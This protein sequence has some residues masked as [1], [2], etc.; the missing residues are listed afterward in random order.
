MKPSLCLNMIV[1]N[2]ADRIER[3]LVSAL[4][5]VKSVVIY[6]TISSDDTVD[7]ITTM[8]QN[9]D[10]PYIVETGEFRDFSYA[11]N[12][13][14]KL[15]KR[16]NGHH[17][18]PF[19][20][21]VLL[22]DADMEL[23]V[24]DG[25]GWEELFNSNALSFDMMQKAGGISYANRRIVNLQYPNDNIYVGV[26]HEYI[27][28]APSGMIKGAHFVDHADGSNRKDKYL[29]DAQ[30]LEDALK[31]DPDNGRSL[32]YL[33]NTYSDWGDTDPSKL[34]LAANAYMKRIA[35]GGW[36]EEKHSSMMRLADV[37]RKRGFEDEYV[38]RMLNAFAFRPTRVE[39][40]YWLA[41]YYRNKGEPLA[42]LMF[43]KTG[44][45]I[46]R[47]DDLLFVNDFAYEWGCR[48][49]YSIAG[50]YDEK[51]RNS[52]FQV[53]ND[54]A[55]DP[56]CPDWY[57]YSCR[58]NLYW[59]TKPLKEHCP[60]MQR[61]VVTIP[62][63]A[64]YVAMNPS[65][66]VDVGGHINCNF[67]CVNYKIDEQ[68]RYMIGPLEC[69]DAA[70]ET[71]NFL[72]KLDGEFNVIKM[73]EILWDRPAAKFDK[74]IGLEDIRLYR[75]KG[76][77]WFNACVREQASNGTCQQWRGKLVHDIDDKYMLVKDDGPMSGEDAIEKNWMPISGSPHHF[78]YRLDKIFNAV[79]G[80]TTKYPTKLAVG[81]IAGG[82]Q[83]I[84][85][86][87]GYICVVHEASVGPDN[88]RTYWHRF[89]WLNHDL[90]LRRL[91]L[92]FV[93]EDQQIEFCAGLAFHPNGSDFML[94]Y[95]VRD[96]E[97]HFA[98]V[99]MEEVAQM[100]WKFHES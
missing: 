16:H 32:F 39:P 67:R 56:A 10:I 60:S 75:H 27:D 13:A 43:A 48:Y 29:R 99:N 72:A 62:V 59:Y 36:D 17:T 66:E 74:V 28:V 3:C 70:I 97:A 88:K 37:Q 9:S 86:R 71:R 20:Q 8:C 23:A 47:P 44:M 40:L 11:R 98:T 53:T 30:L 50:Y 52:A 69:N 100:L 19:C 31:T 42:A 6:D 54:L 95:G 90:E 12:N 79:S 7:R 14:W 21:F 46:K 81:D 64:G 33:A 73:R 89:A 84:P 82:S 58:T 93:L 38:G 49:E 87:H 24:D 34:P 85:F 96:A 83:A 25:Y 77:L 18:L 1:K 15:A 68:G 78:V 63:P 35:Q 80:K 55:L 4:P 45:A 94:S 57:R 91:S 51:E 76:E 65:L 5:H 61:C 2:E 41:E 92:P 26:T 22:M